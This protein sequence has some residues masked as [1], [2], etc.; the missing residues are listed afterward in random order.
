MMNKTLKEKSRCMLSRARF[1][2]EFWVEA[3]GTSCY[4][5]NRSPSSTLDERTPH[6]V[7]TRNKPSLTH[8]WVFGC[9]AYVHIPK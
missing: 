4:L 2:Q 1:R 5:V 9:E 7:W 3:V 6:D 8:L